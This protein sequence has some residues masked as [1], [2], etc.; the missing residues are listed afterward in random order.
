MTG[1]VHAGL[2]QGIAP[3]HVPG[4]LPAVLQRLPEAIP[5][6]QVRATPTGA[7][8]PRNTESSQGLSQAFPCRPA[9]Y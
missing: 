5:L 3:A 1:L 6:P 9:P 8:G 2:L 7:R 4:L